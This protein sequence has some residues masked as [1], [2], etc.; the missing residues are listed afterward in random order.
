M[1]I[2]DFDA[3]RDKIQREIEALER[4]LGPDF[5]TI[6]VVLS[7][8]SDESDD[9]DSDSGDTLDEDLEADEI[10]LEDGGHRA[11]MCLQMNLVYQAVLQE[12]LQEMELLIAQNKVQQEELL[13]EL[14][15][16]RTQ[17]VGSAK[18]YPANLSIGHF[19]KPYFKDKSSG[20]GPPANPEMIERS[21]H[22]LKSFKEL[23]SRKWR[24]ADNEELRKAIV[25]DSLQR[26]LQP[27]LL[28]FEYLQQK[29][30]NAKNDVDKSI[31]AKQIQEVERDIDDINQLPEE[32]LLGQRTDDHD[33]EKISNVYFEGIH[34]ADRI[35]KIWKNHLHPH[36]NKE[37]W[38]EDEIKK[39]QEIAKE[40]NCVNWEL[41]AEE[42]GTQRTAFQCL[43]QFQ[44]SS[45][46][47]KR[48]EF[49]KEEDE[50]LMYFVQRMRVGMHIPY[51]KISYFMEGRDSMQLLNRW[52][53]C[54][55]PYLKKG[56]WSKEEDALLLKA[57]EKYGEKDWYKIR[58]E[59]PGRS[60]IQCRERYYKGLHKDVKKGKWTPEEEEKLVELTKKY[61]VG[62]WAKVG[63][64]I[65]HRTGS[66]CLSKWKN[67]NGYFKGK[68]RKRKRSQNTAPQKRPRKA[69][70]QK[71]PQ[72]KAPKKIKEEEL[73]EEDM[74]DIS[75]ESSSSSFII[76]SSSTSSIHSSSSSCSSSSS[77]SSSSSSSS[78]EDEDDNEERRAARRFLDSVPE[79][80]L[81]IPRKKSP[82][83]A[84]IKRTMISSSC[85]VPRTRVRSRRDNYQFNT[86]LKG[87]A[88]PPSTDTV[89]E[90]PK[91]ILLQA[92]NSGHDIVQLSEYDVRSVLRWN[93]ILCQEKQGQQLSQTQKEPEGDNEENLGPRFAWTR[94][95][96]P[97]DRSLLAAVTPW[98][99]NV[100]LPLLTL[101]KTPWDKQIL[102]DVM[103]KKLSSVTI[104][105]TPIFTLLIQFFQINAAGCLEMISL[106][107]AQQAEFLKRMRQKSQQKT[108]ANTRPSKS[109]SANSSSAQQS[110]PASSGETEPQTKCQ[111]SQRQVR[112]SAVA[113]KPKTVFELLK[114]KRLQESRA[115]RR[116]VIPPRILISPQIVLTQACVPA[117]QHQPPVHLATSPASPNL[118]AFPVI[119]PNDVS[120]NQI[121][122]ASSDSVNRQGADADKAVAGTHNSA[123]ST[124]SPRTV[125]AVP[126]G[127]VISSQQM[128][129]QL[130]QSPAA[131]TTSPR[132]VLTQACAPAGQHPPPVHPATL[133][134]SQS[135][136]VYPVIQTDTISSNH[137]SSASSDSINRQGAD[138]C[139]AMGVTQDAAE[140]TNRHNSA[141]S[142]GS[143]CAV[144]AVPGGQI[145]ASQ[146][147]PLQLLQSPAAATT[148]P[149][150]VLTQACAPAGQ[151]PA[152][153]HPATLT[154]SQNLSAM[155]L[156]MCLVTQA[157][158]ISSNQISSVSSDSVNRQGADADKAK[159]AGTQDAEARNQCNSAPSTGSPCT[160]QAVPG[161]HIIASQQVPIQLL[162]SPAATTF[163]LTP[164]GLVQIPIQALFSAQSQVFM[165]RNSTFSES[166][167]MKAR[168]PSTNGESSDKI[169]EAPTNLSNTASQPLPSN[170][171]SAENTAREAAQLQ[172][173]PPDVSVK[174]PRILPTFSPLNKS[175]E[176][177]IS[178]KM[179]PVVKVAKILTS[180]QPNAFTG[181]VVSSQSPA[182]SQITIKPPEKKIF[183][184]GLISLEDETSVK[185]WLQGKSCTAYLPP[186][187][188]T[189]KTFSRILL[190]KKTLEESA[191]KLIPRSDGGGDEDVSRKQEILD[192]LVEQ[193]L[194]DNPAY[195]LLKKRFLSAFTFSGVLA[196]FAPPK[197]E[198]PTFGMK[199]DVKDEDKMM[200]MDM[201]ECYACNNTDDRMG[202]KSPGPTAQSCPQEG[203]T[204]NPDGQRTPVNTRRRPQRRRVYRRSET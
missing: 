183:D 117:G 31:I 61:G 44:L 1:S 25:S 82:D 93:T 168:E 104:A 200:E 85:R 64:E 102:A 202:G 43:Q 154:A 70:P 103:R 197:N 115:R 151:H 125:Q 141:P 142:T 89:T 54:L 124:G 126:G 195:N 42:L 163:I 132:I 63:R 192:N 177:T 186:S 204:S 155:P 35:S 65:T 138:A 86:I 52:S 130:L 140:A 66:Q 5:S 79:L 57:V 182:P 6:D 41:I 123:P 33:W 157:N 180:N 139:K 167:S 95:K 148:S 156:P 122:S 62:H 175:T 68:T 169:P 77:R 96:T 199:D 185:D 71:R 145:V 172:C 134:T 67:M 39:L 190:Q 4:S 97:V 8:G 15:G 50:M 10:N 116:V 174:M 188:C 21:S 53:K 51:R 38:K 187:A 120:S 161:P 16:R 118:P 178:P 13:W 75:S 74:S 173:P 105:S 17:Q 94:R 146:Q 36:V 46:D 99:G 149:R 112:S 12:K 153:V 198:V 47:F 189:L 160:V 165:N 129:L 111:S 152:P 80:D 100:F 81:W 106:R 108:R 34:N 18:P 88:Y 87:I 76:S 22:T 2:R 26:M 69:A 48:K 119:Q 29:W 128:P 11:E 90:N 9:D 144:Q 196:V 32:T 27:K 158:D 19:F 37:P 60:D 162:Q 101:Y 166:S 14:A 171:S 121:L 55:D 83:L 193:K 58:L 194:K 59:V 109:I 131:A 136:P 203:E 133:T 147:M 150:I 40:H 45:K 23:S 98:V 110:Q 30:D 78:S 72:N 84:S 114:E 137:M 91:D 49:T 28:K 184:L 143:P 164:Q 181:N 113:P 107:K 3:A 127:Q 179:Y 7:G 191:F 56:L 20:V 159:A 201:Y 135:L 24:T 170:G 176:F 73:S 92:K